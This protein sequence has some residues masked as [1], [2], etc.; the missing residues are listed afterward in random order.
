MAGNVGEV[1]AVF[2]TDIWTR[3][4]DAV[5]RYPVLGQLFQDIARHVKAPASQQMTINGKKRKLDHGTAATSAHTNGTAPIGI[6]NST[7]A[8]KYR[9][10]TFQVPA[11]KKLKLQVV[12]DAQDRRRQEGQLQS[13]QSNEVE[14]TL[15][16]GSIDQVFCLPVPDKQQ[17]QWNFVVFPEPGATTAD[18][19]PCEQVVFTQATAAAGQA[20]GDTECCRV[21]EQYT[22]IAP[23][24]GE[25]VPR[26]SIQRQQR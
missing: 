21:R 7:I 14:H 1:E 20:C 15:P 25:G 18:S 26:E 3:I 10:I 13:Q 16:A 23:Q 19:M 24:R 22:A 6:G 17:R 8:F 11:R 12:V 9:D 2:P 5:Q 4:A